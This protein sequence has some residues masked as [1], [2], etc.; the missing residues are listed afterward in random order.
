[1]EIAIGIAIGLV[2]GILI[3]AFLAWLSRDKP[4]NDDN[5]RASGY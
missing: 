2:C 5:A 1:M 3:T 4:S